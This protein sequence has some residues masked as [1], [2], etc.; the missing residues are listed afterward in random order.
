MTA[1]DIL[2]TIFETEADQSGVDLQNEKKNMYHLNLCRAW[3]GFVAIIILIE[4]M[5]IWFR[6]CF[7]SA[8]KDDTDFKHLFILITLII[9][10]I[11]EIIFF[12]DIFY[13]KIKILP[14]LLSCHRIIYKNFDFY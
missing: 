9:E 12:I 13:I 7:Y 10:Y 2:S 11:L 5:L 3:D 14:S 6:L 1:T 8:Y 4:G